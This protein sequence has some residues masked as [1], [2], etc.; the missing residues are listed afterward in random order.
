MISDP[1]NDML[2]LIWIS[3]F[4]LP[5]GVAFARGGLFGLGWW[6]LANLLVGWHPTFWILM[7]MLARHRHA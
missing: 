3:V 1:T 2:L 6:A 4:A 7:L 5:T